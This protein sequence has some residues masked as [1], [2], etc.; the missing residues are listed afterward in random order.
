MKREGVSSPAA[1]G[2]VCFSLETATCH[3]A[4]RG[5]RLSTVPMVHHG[6]SRPSPNT[7]QFGVSM[8]VFYSI[9]GIFF[10]KQHS[11]YQEMWHQEYPAMCKQSCL[12]FLPAPVLQVVH[13][14]QSSNRQ[15]P[16]ISSEAQ[17]SSIIL[18][19]FIF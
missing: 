3:C 13:F 8:H 6:H 7:A 11:I 16:V 4:S 15:A 10:L 19:F 1:A 5:L 12:V 9:K 2:V 17:T 18:C 14:G